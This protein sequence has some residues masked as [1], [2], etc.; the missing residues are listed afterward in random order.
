MT[1]PEYEIH[2]SDC[3][4]LCNRPLDDLVHAMPSCE[5][6]GHDCTCT[7]SQMVAV[8]AS[9]LE[10]LRRAAELAVHIYPSLSRLESAL[11]PFRRGGS[12]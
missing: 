7:G 8:K 3:P 12:A 4:R 10:E 2:A 9:E 5:H 6:R 1:P 11:Q